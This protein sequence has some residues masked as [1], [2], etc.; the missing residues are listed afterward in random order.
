M[1]RAARAAA[2]AAARRGET[3]DGGKPAAAVIAPPPSAP[4]T[5]HIIG[6][7][8]IPPPLGA[9]EGG[10]NNPPPLGAAKAPPGAIPQNKTAIPT[11]P[12]PTQPNKRDPINHQPRVL[13]VEPR[14]PVRLALV[15]KLRASGAAA[16]GVRSSRQAVQVLLM[17]V[18]GGQAGA[19]GENQDLR[20]MNPL[21]PV[22]CVPQGALGTEGGSPDQGGGGLPQPEPI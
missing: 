1:G 10:V 21:G 13:V 12:A 2:R 6:D 18:R 11:P 19:R 17:A 14:D 3:G 7:A 8:I 20:G 4:S 16:A 9:E 5:G 22:N 15:E